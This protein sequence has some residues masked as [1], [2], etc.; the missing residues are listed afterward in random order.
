MEIVLHTQ[1]RLGS[2]NTRRQ[3]VDMSAESVR[4]CVTHSRW[5]DSNSPSLICLDGCLFVSEG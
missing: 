3:K 2:D 1:Y 4:S 5:E